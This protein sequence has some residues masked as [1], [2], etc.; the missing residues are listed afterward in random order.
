MKRLFAF[1]LV[2]VMCLGLCACANNDGYTTDPT[3]SISTTTES[4]E[5]SIGNTENSTESTTSPT[6]STEIPTDEPTSPPS[7]APTETPTEAPT[8]APTEE[9][10]APPTTIPDETESEEE[11]M[12]KLIDYNNAVDLINNLSTYFDPDQLDAMNEAYALLAK[13]GNYKDAPELL[14]HFIKCDLSK[15]D[16]TMD[17]I[18]LTNEAGQTIAAAS[19]LLTYTSTFEFNENGLVVKETRLLKN[20]VQNIT[21]DYNDAGQ[22]VKEEISRSYNETCI[23][24]QYNEAGQLTLKESHIAY[25]DGDKEYYRYRYEY[26]PNGDIATEHSYQETTFGTSD[27]QIKEKTIQYSYVYD[28]NGLLIEKTDYY[29]D[30]DE[31]RVLTYQHDAEGRVIK[32]TNQWK[33]KT[34]SSTDISNIS[35]S[36]VYFYMPQPS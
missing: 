1:V 22:L 31:S 17:G 7:E 19:P 6:E 32:I 18:V 35:Y 13:L 5:I 16:N 12:Q 26:N 20:E 24:Y 9:T 23:T 14:A 27:V 21:Y 3:E 29:P 4:T 30:T 34:Y 10:T 2:F 15:S 28:E 11:R 33:G 25:K 8:E 36:T